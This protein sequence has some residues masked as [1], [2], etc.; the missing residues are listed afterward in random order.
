MKGHMNNPGQQLSLAQLRFVE[1]ESARYIQKIIR[2]KFTRKWYK[3]YNKR[4][5]F[6]V[7]FSGI[8]ILQYPFLRQ[9]A[10]L[11]MDLHS[12]YKRDKE[13]N[14]AVKDDETES[15]YK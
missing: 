3:A 4:K 6:G 10:K 15:E 1:H 12:D 7:P 9:F 13:E 8:E 2:G 5:H 14:E 11:N